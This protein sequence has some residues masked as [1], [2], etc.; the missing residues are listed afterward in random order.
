MR[1]QILFPL[2]ASVT[3][4]SGVGPRTSQAIRRL[5]GERVIDALWH[6]PTAVID[7]S[8]TPRLG[9]A[10]SGSVVTVTVQIV[11]H[12]PSERRRLPYRIRCSDDTGVL[13][14]VYFHARPQHLQSLLPVGAKR[15][16]SGT[17]EK[18]GTTLQIL[19]PDYVVAPD[20]G[21]ALP[22][23]EP[24]YPLTEGLTAK[25]LLRVRRAA[26]SKAPELDEWL[27]PAYLAQRGWP[28]W[29]QA[30]QQAHE[31]DTISAV[32][33]TAPARARLAFDEL[34]ANQL[35]LGMIRRRMK[36]PTGQQIRSSEDLAKKA[37]SFLGFKLTGS[38]RTTI[39]EITRDMASGQRMHR[40][41]HGDVGSGKT[42]VA[43]L[44]MMRAVE[45]GTQA[46][47]MAPTDILAKQH[48]A[49]IAPVASALGI[50]CELLTG[51]TSAKERA[52]I[53][54]G[55]EN[56][57]VQI[58]IG[59]HA[60]IQDVISFKALCLAIVDEQHRFGVK[61]RLALARKGD[62]VHILVMT[63]T[64]IPRTLMLTAYGDLDVSRLSEKPPGRQPVD[65]RVIP[66]ERIDEVIS[67]IRRSI[68]AGAKVYW[69]C[70]LVTESETLDVAAAEDRARSLTTTFGARVGLV[71]GRMTADA[72]QQIM[73]QFT[74]SGLDILVATTVIEV[75]IDVPD[76]SIMVI[77]HAERFGLAQLH[78]LRG[79]V[80]RGAHR[81][82]CILLY[83]SP[84]GKIAR[85]RLSILRDCDDGF[86]IAD[87]DLKLRGAGE[88]LGVRQSG[89]PT[90]RLADLNV[91]AELLLA[92]RDDAKLIL[93]RDPELQ[94]ARGHALRTLLYLFE[95][96]EAISLVR[97]G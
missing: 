56:G 61:Q 48:L 16:V 53:T 65:T 55:L 66:N 93:E 67:A 4:L 19:H 90:F 30:L 80:G 70:P 63:A 84:L 73:S 68:E 77:E 88:L 11:E 57:T 47:L 9:E 82:S 27:D 40:L 44:A 25:T 34:L 5:A 60:L 14:L 58:V 24:V 31:P 79:R 51:R 13:D 45:A 26:L 15:I 91:H 2:F 54:S 94:S 74:G 64:P 75:G 96:D 36:T 69:V 23:L 97:S 81:S 21:A 29:Q 6:L 20:Q 3:T 22:K 42:V 33:P 95:Q 8:Y 46:A 52:R 72:K 92:A 10:R 35:A 7:R 43:L 41:L 59:T 85:A 1:P 18:Y 71:H 86:Q 28:S 87:E 38:Q 49:T 37:H 89:S 62:G 17:L 76:A 39:S 12:R 83:A 50:C 78:Q 32:E